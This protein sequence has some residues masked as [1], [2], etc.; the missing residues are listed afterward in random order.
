MCNVVGIFMY[1]WCG[2]HICLGNM[3][4]MWKF[5]HGLSI[6]SIQFIWVISIDI[7]VWYMHMKYLAYVACI[8]QWRGRFVV[9]TYNGNSML[10]KCHNLLFLVL[11]YAVML[12][13]YV[14]NHITIVGHICQ[15]WRYICSGEYANNVKCMYNSVL[16]HTLSCSNFIWGIITSIYLSACASIHLSIS[17]YLSI[18][19]PTY[20][21][22]TVM[23]LHYGDMVCYI[24]IM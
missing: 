20:L 1:V 19:L 14:D 11:L 21:P 13:L 8:L 10:I 2:R 23:Q 12:G 5:S 18:Y 7:V 4:I 6:D 16:G 22:I 17:I 15:V 9:G 24:M 3:P